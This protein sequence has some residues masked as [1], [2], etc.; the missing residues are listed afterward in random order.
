MV[1]ATLRSLKSV[2]LLSLILGMVSVTAQTT[3]SA[4]AKKLPAKKA[5]KKKAQKPQQDSLSK[6]SAMDTM[7]SGSTGDAMRFNTD[8]APASTDPRPPMM[9]KDPGAAALGTPPATFN[10]IPEDE[11]FRAYI[12]YPKHQVGLYVMPISMSSTWTSGTNSYSFKDSPL[13]YGIMYRL[14][15]SPLWQMELDY[16]RYTSKMTEATVASLRF[17]DSKVDLDNY[18]YRI[19]ACVIGN[20]G[21]FHQLCPGL[22]IGNDSYPVL[23]YVTSS[24]L[25]LT[26]FQDIMIGVNLKYTVPFGSDFLFKTALGYDYGT[27]LGNAGVFTSKGNSSYFAKAG[28]EYGFNK[29]HSLNAGLE[30]KARVA[31]VKGTIGSATDTWET[32]SA[33]FGGNLGWLFTF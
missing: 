5:S 19:N 6:Q 30:F 16:N 8:S 4:P 20:R 21:F 24:R 32:K 18:F 27:G 33:A 22:E 31:K 25:S 14:V 12:G 10:S 15:V 23:K 13:G 2:L 29:H 28:L 7:S 11:P 17:L 3:S 26:K 9:F 1:S